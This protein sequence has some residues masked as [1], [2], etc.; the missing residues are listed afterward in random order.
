MNLDLV[1][2]A[3][4]SKA[5]ENNIG[6]QNLAISKGLVMTH[7]TDYIGSKYHWFRSRINPVEIEI[8]RILNDHQRV[9]TFTKG[10][11]ILSFEEKSN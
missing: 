9:Y 8:N 5:W 7:R 2:V 3:T 6:T 4:V 10:S 11:T 1:G